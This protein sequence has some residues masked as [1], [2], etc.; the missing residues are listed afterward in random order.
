ME[1][2]FVYV[3]Q[4][5]EWQFFTSLT[6]KSERLPERVRLS[7]FFAW[8]RNVASWH[9]INFRHLLWCLRM[10]PGEITGRRHF[11]ALIA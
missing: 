10:E 11:H 6:F 8:A 3:L 4:F 7:V 1:S 2:P 5:V 9:N